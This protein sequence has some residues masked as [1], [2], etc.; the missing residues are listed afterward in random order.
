M[1]LINRFALFI[2]GVISFILALSPS[3]SFGFILDNVLDNGTPNDPTDDLLGAARWNNTPGSL[4]GSGTRGLGGGVEYSITNDFC[5]RLIP[6]FIDTPKPNCSQVRSAI[7][8]AT[9]SVM[10]WL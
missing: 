9:K 4:V 2:P 5:A 1:H 7:R 10:L 8:R 3:S 6:Q